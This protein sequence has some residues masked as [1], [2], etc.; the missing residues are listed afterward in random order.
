MERVIALLREKNDYLEKFYA[1]NEHEL[2]NFGAGDF[3]NV[4][5]FYQTRDKFLELIHCVDQL[6]EDE[7]NRMFIN[8]TDENRYE[9]SRLFAEKDRLANAI[10]AQDVE[11]L[12]HIDREKT[13]IIKELRGTQQARRAVGAYASLE[14]AKAMED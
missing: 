4:E 9:V 2:I 8:D 3:E 14:R 7:R 12:A 5:I 11:I 10:L 13:K 6:L 1:I